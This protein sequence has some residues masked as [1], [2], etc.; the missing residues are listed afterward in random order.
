MRRKI[1]DLDPWY[2]TGLVEGEGCFHVGFTFRKKLKIGIETRPSFSISL[3]KRDVELLKKV[4]KYFG[5]GAIRYS[6]SDHTYKYE[7][8]SV[9]DIVKKILPHFE[10]YPLKGSKKEDFEKFKKIVLMVHQNKHLSKKY[11]PEIINLAYSMNPSGK[12]KHR[13]EDLLRVL[14]EVKV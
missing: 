8:R 14:G 4:R 7:V 6:N 12:R 1:M 11:L 10:E 2:I 13:K 5:C 3:N 9:K